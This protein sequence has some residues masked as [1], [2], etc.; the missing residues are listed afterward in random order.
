MP[1]LPPNLNTKQIV[2]FLRNSVKLKAHALGV[3]LREVPVDVLS[4]ANETYMQRMQARPK[5]PAKFTKAIEQAQLLAEQAGHTSVLAAVKACCDS[6]VV[7]SSFLDW[8]AKDAR[9]FSKPTQV[10]LA[11][12][13][14]YHHQSRT[15]R[16]QL[17]GVAIYG[18]FEGCEPRDSESN[19][20]DRQITFITGPDGQPTVT[21][22]E[23]NQLVEDRRTAIIDVLC[24]R[25]SSDLSRGVGALLLQYCV[26]RTMNYTHPH[27]GIFAQLVRSTRH[28]GRPQESH[29][30]A[31]PIFRQQGFRHIQTVQFK[32]DDDADAGTQREEDTGRWMFLGGNGWHTVFSEDIVRE[33]NSLYGICPV[34]PGVRAS[35]PRC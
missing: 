5:P 21:A 4:V 23:L 24:R 2:G 35:L 26:V 32:T 34:T 6:S 31:A 14:Q 27:G 8:A 15:Y 12:K 22:D 10:V 17:I 18:R 29:Y 25:Q 3:I 9:A 7:G 1:P 28:T 20:M 13:N 30:M 16:P 11:Y 19:S 33:M